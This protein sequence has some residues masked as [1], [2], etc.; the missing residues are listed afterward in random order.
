MEAHREKIPCC[1]A[2]QDSKYLVKQNL[3]SLW[4]ITQCPDWSMT[5]FAF[6]ISCF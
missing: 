6:K 1:V 3:S 2:R 4:N 5:E